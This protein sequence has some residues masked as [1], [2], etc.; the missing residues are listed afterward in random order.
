MAVNPISR[1]VEPVARVV[2]IVFGYTIL[3]YSLALSAEIIGRKL[4]NTSFKGIDEVGGFVLA[5]SAAIG[6]SYTMAMRGHTRVDV[7][8]VRLPRKAQRV[9]NTLAMVSMAGFAVFAAFRGVAVLRETIEFGSVSSNLQQ[10]LWIPQ[11]LWATGLGL[12]GVIATA[13]AAHAVWLLARGAPELNAF[14]GPLTVDD[15]I[16][17]ELASLE[18]RSKE[19]ATRG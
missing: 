9:L 18:A 12:F 4:F 5:A 2:A 13:Y 6:A 17:G 3:A 15:E 14:Y 10:P 7:F 19:G 11:A 1:V 8:L 16:E